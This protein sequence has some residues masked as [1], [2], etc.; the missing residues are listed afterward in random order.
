M[1]FTDDSGDQGSHAPEGCRNE[2]AHASVRALLRGRRR[3]LSFA[4]I[5]RVS[6]RSSRT[7]GRIV[8]VNRCVGRPTNNNHCATTANH[9]T[10]GCIDDT[11]DAIDHAGHFNTHDSFARWSQFDVDDDG[12]SADNRNASGCSSDAG[13]G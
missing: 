5:R 4:F 3:T 8:F 10:A 9:S 6:C 2:Q 11:P 12:S 7:D 1:K 13:V